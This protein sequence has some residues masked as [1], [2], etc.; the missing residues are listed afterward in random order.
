MEGIN[1]TVFLRRAELSYMDYAGEVDVIVNDILSFCL[2]LVFSCVRI[3]KG[4]IQS[5]IESRDVKKCF[6]CY[7]IQLLLRICCDD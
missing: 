1:Y 6:T 3:G 7:D 5:A 4:K 2:V